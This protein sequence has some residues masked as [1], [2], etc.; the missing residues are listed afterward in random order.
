MSDTT[1]ISVRCGAGKTGPQC[2]CGVCKFDPKQGTREDVAKSIYL[3]TARFDDPA[4]QEEY[5]H[6]L[7][8]CG[9]IIRSGGTIPYDSDEL[10]HIQKTLRILGRPLGMRDWL[11]ILVIILAFLAIPIM[12]I[13]VFI[14]RRR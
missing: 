5:R 8:E 9:R 10:L 4:D 11:K 7:A 14:F 3:S 12:A 6:Q 2:S 13:I 1:A